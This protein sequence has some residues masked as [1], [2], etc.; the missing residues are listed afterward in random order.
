MFNMFLYTLQADLCVDRVMVIFDELLR[1]DTECPLQKW[2]GLVVLALRACNM[3]G[4]ELIQCAQTH[5][6]LRLTN[7]FMPQKN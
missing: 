2:K 1:P 7:S 6:T 4:F 5:E 3:K